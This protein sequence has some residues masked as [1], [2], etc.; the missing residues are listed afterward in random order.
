MFSLIRV[1]IAAVMTAAM[2]HVSV[3]ASAAD[4]PRSHSVIRWLADEADTN[5][6]I[7]EVSG[8]SPAAL[9]ELRRVNWTQA[10]WQ[11]LFSVHAEQGDLFANVG[12]PPMLGDYKII[13][14]TLRFEPQFP[15]APAVTYAATFQPAVLPGAG[16]G[17]AI[18]SSVHRTTQAAAASKTIVAHIY[19]TSSIVPENLLKFYIQFSASMNRG[20]I[21]DHIHL[22]DAR[23]KDVE[24]P[25]LEIDEELWNQDMT[26]LTLFIDPGRI[27]RGVR[28][29]EE[30]G[31]A[32]EDGKSFTLAIDSAWRDATGQPLKTGYQKK[33]RVGPPDREPPDPAKWKI[34][35]PASGK[36]QPLVIK[37]PEPFDYALAL[38]VIRVTDAGGRLVPGAT[39]L[40]DNERRWNFTPAAPW[41][42]GPHH[43]VVQTTIEDLAGNNIGKA[44]DVDLFDKVERQFTNTS[45]NIPFIVR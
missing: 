2:L 16:Q 34:D 35:P 39:A 12:L 29:L 10:Q 23:G 9:D 3:P 37:F 13:A 42:R 21:Y 43:L 40:A 24:L 19:P 17:A 5:R 41:T 44:F 14:G 25:F 22:R 15:L 20:Y 45:V 6:T 28:P 26:R 32:L 4:K 38:R 27:K 7:L 18:V 30:I 36:W 8:I 31:P 11:K 33:F 1:S